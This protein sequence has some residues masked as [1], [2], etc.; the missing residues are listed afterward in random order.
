MPNRPAV[1]D[2]VKAEDNKY[3]KRKCIERYFDEAN[4]YRSPLTREPMGDKLL[5]DSKLQAKI[6]S[7]VHPDIVDKASLASYRNR[8]AEHFLK[9]FDFSHND[10]NKLR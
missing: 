10:C 6:K 1:N 4:D 5:P 2:P 9:N 7:A 3:C 8:T